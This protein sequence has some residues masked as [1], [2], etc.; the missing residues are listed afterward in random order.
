MSALQRERVCDHIRRG[1]QEGARL[2]TGGAEAHGGAR[3]RLLR[4]ADGF[5]DVRS[6]MTI[7]QEEIF[8]PVLR[9]SPSTT[10]RT[11][12]DR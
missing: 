7:A 6:D 10:R 12:S 11:R 3:P 9:S 4:G 8:G 1:N 5:S 2:V